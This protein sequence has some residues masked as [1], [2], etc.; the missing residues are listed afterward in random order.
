MGMTVNGTLAGLVG[1]TAGAD[2]V[3]AAAAIGVGLVAG[4]LVVYAVKAVDRLKIDDAVGAFAVHGVCG[5]L[6]T[7]WVGFYALEAAG[8]GAYPAGLFHGG[9][10]AGVIAQVTGTVTVVAFVT[11]AAGLLGLLLKAT[12]LLRV[13]EEEE[14][15]GLDLHEHGMYGYPEL[16]LG[17]SAYPGGPVT[18]EHGHTV[19]LT[20]PAPAEQRPAGV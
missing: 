7:W 17:A 2:R 10:F 18:H 16:A 8:D 4:V 11:V 15:E 5:V 3:S 1:I 12:N 6:G 20:R 13:S 14:L 19:D 9:G